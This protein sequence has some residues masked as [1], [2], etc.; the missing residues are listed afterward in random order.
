[1]TRQVVPV[2]LAAILAFSAPAEA[3]PLS[4]SDPVSSTGVVYRTIDADTFIFNI[5]DTEA[6]RRLVRQAQGDEDRERY[7]HDRFQSTRIRL[8][9]VDTP[10]STHKDEARNSPE[11]EK[12]SRLVT[13]LT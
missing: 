4:G 2:T 5:D 12:A 6:Y 7:L 8:A 3:G 11:G 10:E 13:D 9:N 1:M